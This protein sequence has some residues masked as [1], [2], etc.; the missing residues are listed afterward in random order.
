MDVWNIKSEGVEQYIHKDKS[1]CKAVSHPR[2]CEVGESNMSKGFVEEW[3]A[4][5]GY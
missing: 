2:E 1:S 3:N 5:M 4:T